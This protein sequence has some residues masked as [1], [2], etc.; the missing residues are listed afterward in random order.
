MFN[1]TNFTNF[2]KSFFTNLTKVFQNSVDDSKLVWQYVGSEY[3]ATFYFPARRW[4]YTLDATTGCQKPGTCPN[5]DPRFRPWY[6]AAASGPKK[7]VLVIDTS[8]SM[9]ISNRM[10][11]AIQAAKTIIDGLGFVDFVSVVKV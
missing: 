8:G 2:P 11:T 9:T 6:I 10:A 4:K 5:Y 7:V 1:C 3:G